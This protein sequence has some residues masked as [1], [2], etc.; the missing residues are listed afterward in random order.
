MTVQAYVVA[1]PKQMNVVL[2]IV[3]LQMIALRIVLVH[4]VEVLN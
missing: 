1:V 2:V 4:G 3:M